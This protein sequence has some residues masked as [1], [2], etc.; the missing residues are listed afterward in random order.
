[1]K[2]LL[3]A[4]VLATG[5]FAM[6]VGPVRADVTPERSARRSTAASSFSRMQQLANGSWAEL[7]PQEHGGITAPLH[8][9][10]A[11]FRRRSE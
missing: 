7:M 2:C 6:A 8:A 10:L 1:M 5:L 3:A 9:G 11:G 4:L